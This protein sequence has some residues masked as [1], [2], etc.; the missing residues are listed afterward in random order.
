MRTNRIR[1]TMKAR[2]RWIA[3][4]VLRGLHR[5]K[6][7]TLAPPLILALVCV[8]GLSSRVSATNHIVHIDEVMAG[9]N[10]DS[11]IQFIE[12]RASDDSQKEWGPN[13]DLSEEAGRA[14]LVFFDINGKRTG[15]FVFPTNAPPGGNQVLIA[16]SA[17]A[18]L[19][20]APRPDFIMP[21]DLL[22][23]S[24]KVCFRDNPANPNRFFV[25]LCLSYGAFEGDTEGAGS[26]AAG[27]ARLEIV[28]ATSLRRFQNFFS[29][30]FQSN[31]DFQSTT[32][33]PTNTRD[34]T[35]TFGVA[36]QVEQGRNLFLKETFN[37]NGR[38]CR[39]CHIAGDAFGLSPASIAALPPSD[40]LFIADFN[41]NTLV[42]T[43]DSRPSD[44][45]GVITAT[46]G[47]T[48][49][50]VA[51]SGATYLIHGGSALAGTI[52][53]G[54]NS[55][56][57]LSFTPGDLNELENPTLLSGGRALILENIDGFANP[58]V[59]RAS[60]H[61][62]NIGL[63][64]PYGQSGEIPDLRAFTTGAVRQHF[65]R[66]LDRSENDSATQTETLDFRIPTLAERQAMEAFMRTIFL[67]ADQDFDLDR[68]ATTEAQ[69]R[70]GDLFF[71]A[72][73]CSTCHSGAVLAQSDGRFGTTAGVNQRFNT[74]VA[75]LPINDGLPREPA[76][77]STNTREFS[78][79]PLF[80]VKNTAPFFHDNSVA[81]LQEAVE[82]YDSR[83]F[84]NSPAGQQI[85]PINLSDPR[86]VADLLAFLQSLTQV[87]F[88]MT[89]PSPSPLSF[90][91]QGVNA[92]AT[93]ARTV[94][95][96]NTGSA[97]IAVT[98]AIIN[99]SGA[100]HFSITDFPPAAP[101]LPGESRTVGIAFDPAALGE[102]AA[103][104]ELTTIDARDDWTVGVPLIGR[105]SGGAEIVV[106]PSSLAFGNQ[107]TEA[108]PT[109]SQAVS[110]TNTGTA[111]L[112]ISSLALAGAAPS[113]FTIVG[114]SGEKTLGPGASRTV[115]IAFDPSVAG[116]L[117][118]ILSIVSNDSD[119][120]TVGV[121]LSGSGI[122]DAEIVVTPS[123]LAFGGQNTEAGPTGSQAVSITNTGTADLSISSLA[124]AGAAPSQFT[125]VG[126]S[127]EKTL[128]PGASRTVRIAF[129][130]AVA[131]P[132]EA[133]LIIVSN[134]SDQGTV[135]VTLTG[136]GLT[137]AVI[138]ERCF[139]RQA[140]IV[141]TEGPERLDGTPGSDVIAALG[142]NDIVNGRGGNDFLCG[143]NGND[144]IKGGKGKDRLDGGSGRDKLDGG[145][146]PDRC[147]GGSG[148]DTAR[149]CE[150]I[151][152]IP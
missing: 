115:R 102:L 47:S 148:R 35:F 104:L 37:G 41:L 55:G 84:V 28:G 78:V 24:G 30:G 127:G 62:L 96:T 54:V 142:G 29:F 64:A 108:G 128:G 12:M 147:I 113:Q 91:E 4:V 10:G 134:D 152:G 110:I 126:D 44:L 79:P 49:T 71:G 86:T 120:G 137:P 42:L 26:P 53:D 121:P 76:T 51:G 48:A 112:S 140:T 67:P 60:P 106:T 81:T 39:T 117:E 33:E 99:G 93:P 149:N 21:T 8:F 97:P 68:F 100:A 17:F 80:G 2:S 144:Q 70:G 16:T 19:P 151:R 34:Q 82:F 87:P 38:T 119:Q 23:Q 72:A 65:P 56:E 103:T 75:D 150:R 83:E 139:G 59:M 132:L 31:A 130:P 135:G 50:I 25:N 122:G 63:T 118:A 1:P 6:A 107:N 52:T 58:P 111:D 124:L 145:G 114:D 45:R 36:S 27:G 11:R 131:G 74:G 61:L 14:M 20:G 89:P 138:T 116:P 133:S 5:I 92:G 46:N 125:I 105:G 13:R 109:G 77:S 22:A 136:T 32:P 94:L 7:V 40:P 98:A 3:G 73:K 90:G 141:G 88:A 18:A 101:F 146:N 143:G 66:R 57:L 43:D 9:A 123:S 129:D 15:R 69:K 85:G 95:V